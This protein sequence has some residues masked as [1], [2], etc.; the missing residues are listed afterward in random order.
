MTSEPLVFDLNLPGKDVVRLRELRSQ[1]LKQQQS[2]LAFAED[3][4]FALEILD[5]HG[6]T[7]HLLDVR[8]LLQRLESVQPGLIAHFLKTRQSFTPQTLQ[9]SVERLVSKAE[10]RAD[11]NYWASL[12]RIFFEGELLPRLSAMSI[13]LGGGRMD[14]PGPREPDR[15]SVLH[16]SA[17]FA[18]EMA[19]HK[20]RFLVRPTA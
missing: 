14:Y 2:G 7:Q 15:Q 11:D 13:A 19:T 5:E 10:R 8:G 17:W 12:A 20:W 9:L 3:G 1:E 4:T 16:L 18:N 6:Q